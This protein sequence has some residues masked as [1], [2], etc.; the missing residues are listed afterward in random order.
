MGATASAVALLL[1]ID[2]PRLGQLEAGLTLPSTRITD[3]HQRLRFAVTA[4]TADDRSSRSMN[5]PRRYYRRRVMNDMNL[6]PRLE[7]RA[8]ARCIIALTIML[9]IV[10]AGPARGQTPP[11]PTARDLLDAA[12]EQL[13][14]AESFRLA[15]EQAGAPYPLALSL[16]GVNTLPATLKRAEAQYMQ[17]NELHISADIVL[18]F[19]LSMD[20]YALDDRQW[21]S[22]PSGAP[23]VVLTPLAGFDV[24]RLLAPGAGIELVL[25]NLLDPQIVGTITQAPTD[26][27]EAEAAALFHLRAQAAGAVVSELLF[28]LIEPQDDVELDAYVTVETGRLESIE[29]TMRETTEAAADEPTVWQIRFYDYDAARGFDPP[30]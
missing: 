5:R 7:C 17:P 15:I 24:N 16:D 18:F 28:G 6:T 30:D 21:I 20:I 26:E 4:P 12:V 11:D 27:P 13:Q 8:A 1:L 29:I 14:A 19:T 3:R 9:C 22:F 25:A 23:W 2:L 10:G